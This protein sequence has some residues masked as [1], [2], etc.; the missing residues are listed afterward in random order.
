MDKQWPWKKGRVKGFNTIRYCLVIY[1]SIVFLLLHLPRFLGISFMAHA[2]VTVEPFDYQGECELDESQLTNAEKEAIVYAQKY[3]EQFNISPALIM[4][5][6]QQESS[7]NP[8]AIGDAGLAIGY[9]QLHWDAAYDAGYKSSRDTFPD[10]SQESKDLARED[11]PLDGIDRDTNVRYGTG[12]ID[13]CHNQYRNDPT[14][15][16]PLKNTISCYNLGRTT[17]PSISNESTYVNPVI[18]FYNDFND[19]CIEAMPQESNVDV[20]LIIDSSGSMTGNDP[21]NNRLKAAR[22]YLTA[23]AAGDFIGV[24]DF[25]GSARLASPLIRL[26]DNKESLINAINTIDSSGGTNIGAGVQ[27]GCDALIASPSDNATKGAILLTNGF[28]SFSGQDQCF[29]SR[30]WPIYTFGLGSGADHPLLRQIAANTGG[31]HTE[32]PASELIC[33]FQRVRSKIAGVDPPPCQVIQIG[34]LEITR[35]FVEVA[36]G[37]LQVT[38]SINWIGSDIEM[39][40]ISPSGRI[41]DRDTTSSDVSHD[42]GDT[43][44]VYTITRPEAGEW[45]AELFGADVPAEGEEVVFG[46]STIP[47]SV[48]IVDIDVKP[49]SDPNSINPRSRGVI[50][51]AILTTSDFDATTV[52]PLSVRF[53]PSGATETHGRGHIEDIDGDGDDDMLLHFRTEET[54][55]QCGD[56][57]VSL[58]GQ[59]SDATLIEG[60]DSIVTVGC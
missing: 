33:E 5:I 49:G 25:D 7:F 34:P 59:T 26:P 14:Y 6:I 12:Y 58:T 35:F 48:I 53:G 46:F 38:F 22:S 10:L 18:G 3:A 20:A 17:G 9:M 15:G 4:A 47:A 36:P 43:F 37:Q 60:S 51:V 29:V 55:I 30:G 39:T 40:L 21:S 50:P 1:M 42:I 8:D 57:S 28:G 32:L 44:E 24:V 16:D 27:V 19:I 52:D 23:S 54:G 56:T 11:W 2:G 41:I 31:E 13:I 45:E